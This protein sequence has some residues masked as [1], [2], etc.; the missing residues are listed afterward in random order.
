M[1][2]GRIYRRPGTDRGAV[3]SPSAKWPGSWQVTTFDARGFSGDHEVE[4]EAHALQDMRSMGYTEEM[5]AEEFNAL[6]RTE[7]FQAGCEL[8]YLSNETRTLEQEIR[9]Q[10]LC[11][12]ANCQP[13]P[14]DHAERVTA[15]W[16]QGRC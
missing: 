14:A 13:V 3:A 15:L 8:T 7:R 16:N 5:P 12:I 6:A 10:E 11:A 2:A 9:F 4:D 1:G